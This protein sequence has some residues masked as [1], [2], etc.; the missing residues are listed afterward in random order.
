MILLITF[1]NQFSWQEQL[2]AWAPYNK[3]TQEDAYLYPLRWQWGGG[4]VP[5]TQ[6]WGCCP[7]RYSRHTPQQGHRSTTDATQGSYTTHMAVGDF[8]LL[9]E[10]PSTTP[11]I[12]LC[13][14]VSS[15][16]E[17]AH[18]SGRNTPSHLHGLN[19]CKDHDIH[20]TSTCFSLHP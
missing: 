5:D 2:L 16:V 10:T 12:H 8:V 6:W 4:C 13:L 3:N 7:S 17:A 9:S 15:M 18:F 14:L 20:L 19:L 1:I 11:R